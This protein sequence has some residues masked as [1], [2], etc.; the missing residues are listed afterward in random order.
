MSTSFMAEILH[1]LLKEA[2]E[3]YHAW[4]AAGLCCSMH[5]IMET[6]VYS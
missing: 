3:F 6:E 5:R 4:P 1:Q 2:S